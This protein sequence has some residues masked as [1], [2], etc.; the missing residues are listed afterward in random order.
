[1]NKTFEKYMEM[2][3]KDS[4]E[5]IDKWWNTNG[6]IATNYV[7]ESNPNDMLVLMK[8]K[9]GSPDAQAFLDS[10]A[11]HQ[12]LQTL[13]VLG[14]RRFEA[15]IKEAMIDDFCLDL[16]RDQSQEVIDEL[17]YPED[18]TDEEEDMF[19]DMEDSDAQDRA[20]ELME[21]NLSLKELKEYIDEKKSDWEI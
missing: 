11:K 7:G 10:T 17:K 15:M 19:H 1:M 8:V 13:N 20:G 16:D 14:I 21:R 12:A 9:P 3:K 4:P 6:D 18:Y 2:A 5:A